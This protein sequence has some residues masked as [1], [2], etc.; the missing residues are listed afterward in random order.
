[1]LQSGQVADAGYDSRWPDKNRL[2]RHS[3][4]LLMM[5]A[6]RPLRL[7]GGPFYI[8][9]YET[10]LA[11]RNCVVCIVTACSLVGG[12]SLIR[13]PNHWYPSEVHPLFDQRYDIGDLQNENPVYAFAKGLRF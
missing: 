5:R 13:S 4:G 8:I 9:S 11:V 1:M 7:T 2:W 10:L 12:Y 3:V 6:Q